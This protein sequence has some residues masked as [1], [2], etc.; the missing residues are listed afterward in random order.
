[1]L[2]A[3][4][5]LLGI[6]DFAFFSFCGCFSIRG[7]GEDRTWGQRG[8]QGGARAGIF[9]FDVMYMF[10]DCEILRVL[11]LLTC[12]CVLMS[13]RT[14]FQSSHCQSQSDHTRTHAA[15][16]HHPTKLFALIIAIQRNWKERNRSPTLYQRRA[17][18]GKKLTFFSLLQRF[19]ITLIYITSTKS[20]NV[21]SLV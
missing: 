20:M 11:A 9:H 16:H 17:P 15:I 5:L 1:L 7:F 14:S 10:Y 19:F 21:L 18:H 13:C 4:A 8:K 3:L 2:L 6:C 12:L